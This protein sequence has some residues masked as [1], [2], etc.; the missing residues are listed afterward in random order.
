MT[1][2]SLHTY[3]KQFILCAAHR[4]CYLSQ[5]STQLSVRS[6]NY[7]VERIETICAS[8][9]SCFLFVC[10]KFKGFYCAA[11]SI[12]PNHGC[13]HRVYRN[14]L[15]FRLSLS[16]DLSK[17]SRLSPTIW[18]TLIALAATILFI[19]ITTHLCAR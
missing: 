2:S 11:H 4:F 5:M 18:S 16:R 13:H 9:S 10:C 8:M 15:L 1:L 19:H 3:R 17:P 6:Q 14:S 12:W 7:V